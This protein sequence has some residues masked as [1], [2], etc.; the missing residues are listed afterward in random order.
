[1][2]V[3]QYAQYLTDYHTAFSEEDVGLAAC[4][5]LHN[6]QYDAADE[7]FS[8]K[9]RV[10]LDAYPLFTGDLMEGLAGFLRQRLSAGEGDLVLQRVLRSPVRPSRKLL[11]HTAEMIAGQEVFTLLDEQLV[12]FESVVAAARR[13]T[14]AP[15]DVH[16]M[17]TE[18]DRYLES[19]AKAG[20][21][22]L[23]VHA[24]ATTRL[25]ITLRRIRELGM[26]PAVALSPASPL[27]LVMEVLGEVDMVLLMT[28][29]P[30]FGGQSFLP[31]VLDK[32]KRLRQ[33]ADGRGYSSLHVEVDGGIDATTAGQVAA[34]GADVL[35]A[36]TAVYGQK[37]YA[38][39]IASIRRAAIGEQR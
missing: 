33:I 10:A 12:V 25:F 2:Q 28:V 9:H 14:E 8:A 16:L 39:A 38:D 6:L 19:F 21:D 5:Y 17:I 37:S 29:E 15:L 27:E 7:L 32:V 36:G 1:V 23:A 13:A 24:E 30:G 26:R 31:F 22:L 35:V 18:P 20:A 4:A 3:G 34:A 11:S